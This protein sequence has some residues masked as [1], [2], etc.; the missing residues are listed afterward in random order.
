MKAYPATGLEENVQRQL[1]NELRLLREVAGFRGVV[2]LLNFVED[3]DFKYVVLE[4]CP[5]EKCIVLLIARTDKMAKH[6]V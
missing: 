4:H 6:L 5:G 2:R 3:E 1:D